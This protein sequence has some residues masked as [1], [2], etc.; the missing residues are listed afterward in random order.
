MRGIC[1]NSEARVQPTH[2][3]EPE[4]NR[5]TTET[6]RSA[7]HHPEC[8]GKHTASSARG[9][10]APHSLTRP[11]LGITPACAGRTGRPCKSLM[12]RRD[13]PR[14]RGENT[15]GMGGWPSTPGSPPR[16]RGEPPAPCSR[17]PGR[18]ITPACAGRT[19]QSSRRTDQ[20]P[21][22]PRVRGENIRRQTTSTA[23][24]G[25]PPRA[26]GEHPATPPSSPAE[27]ITPAC[28]G[29]TCGSPPTAASR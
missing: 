14:V 18:R 22:H 20:A 6:S 19:P 29:R 3:G 5:G 25:S 10:L 28:A 16:A 15:A 13:H 1:R 12:P 21:D 7:S 9:E 27:R 17:P 4:P 23:Y 24:P 26:R 2:R 8:A 11:G